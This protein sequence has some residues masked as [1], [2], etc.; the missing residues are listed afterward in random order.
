M[1]E[2]NWLKTWWSCPKLR[3]IWPWSWTY[4]KEGRC[5]TPPGYVLWCS[6]CERCRGLW[7]AGPWLGGGPQWNTTPGTG[8]PEGEVQLTLPPIKGGARPGMPNLN[9]HCNFSSEWGVLIVSEDVGERGL[10]VASLVIDH[11]FL[12]S[13]RQLLLFEM[14][15]CPIFG[16]AIY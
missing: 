3:N 9:R 8:T 11:Y 5:A 10:E 6:T 1:S 16:R 14:A 7:G 2:T 4:L 13:Q 12:V 15:A